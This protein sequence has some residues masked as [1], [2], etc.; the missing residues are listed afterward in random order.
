M[1]AEP[2]RITSLRKPPEGYEWSPEERERQH[3][4]RVAGPIFHG[5]ASAAVTPATAYI[6]TLRP[7]RDS[8]P[9]AC[10]YCGSGLLNTEPPLGG[11]RRGLISCG[12]C[13]RQLCWLAGTISRVRTPQPAL[14]EPRVAT[15]RPTIDSRFNRGPGCG[16]GCSI[17]FGH[18]PVTH[19]RYGRETAL[20]EMAER[21]SGIVRTGPL[22]ID[23]DAATIRANGRDLPLSPIERGLMLHLA[24]HAGRLCS[25]R[26]IVEAVWD[27]ATADTWVSGK[28][29]MHPLRTHMSRLRTRLGDAAS[30]IETRIGMGY[31]LRTE[32]PT[33]QDG[34]E[35]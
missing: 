19:E 1:V 14:P 27:A 10:Q 22:T 6:P 33:G 16:P 17:V 29:T 13:G 18:D 7:G 3:R 32:P 25:P 34:G 11:H 24:A 9:T 26:Q 12:T 4:A 30:L 35:P 31:L 28:E 2:K 20:A 5:A 23:L 15:L 21:P 8:L